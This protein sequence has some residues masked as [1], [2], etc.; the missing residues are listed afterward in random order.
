M[1][2]NLLSMP[3]TWDLGS[4]LQHST[5]TLKQ[6]G[7]YLIILIGVVMVIASVY[8]IAKGLISHGKTQVSWPVAIILLILGG[9]FMVGGFSFV[10]DIASGGK[11]TIEDLGN[12]TILMLSTLLH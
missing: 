1:M 4:F 2:M 7:G 10:A 5:E 8:Q 3:M 9:A 11:Q 6:W 12:G